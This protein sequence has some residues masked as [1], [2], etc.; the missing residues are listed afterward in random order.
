LQSQ[1]TEITGKYNALSE[2]TARTASTAF[3]DAAIT[4]G[5]VGLKPVRD[6]Y[7]ALHMQDASRAEK[8]IA[9]MPVLKGEMLLETVQADGGKAPLNKD[10]RL[11]MALFGVSEDEYRE[12]LKASGLHKEAL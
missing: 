11:V 9:S 5:R 6:E 1:L 2:A 3:V 10:D 4:A 7:I 12:G 8:L